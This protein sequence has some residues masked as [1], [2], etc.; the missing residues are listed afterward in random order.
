MSLRN[1]RISP[2]S[3]N[4]ETLACDFAGRQWNWLCHTRKLVL[5]TRQ[6]I[7]VQLD[8]SSL[9]LL[10]SRSKAFPPLLDRIAHSQSVS[11]FNNFQPNCILSNF[12]TT[13]T[14]MVSIRSLALL[15]AASLALAQ[16]ISSLQA[17][18]VS[19]SIFRLPRLPLPSCFVLGPVQ[20]FPCRVG[21]SCSIGNY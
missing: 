7:D 16:E 4:S 14:T 6:N 11:G 13:P 5:R 8:D 1:T 2:S 10:A 18:A 20:P 9:A 21:A 3:L 19:R 15:A 12:S 17:C